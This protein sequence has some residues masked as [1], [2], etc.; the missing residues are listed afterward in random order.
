MLPWHQQQLLAMACY[1]S[2]CRWSGHRLLVFLK[3]AGKKLI[4]GDNGAFV[5]SDLFCGH[6]FGISAFFLLRPDTRV[7]K[8]I[9]I[10]VCHSVELLISCKGNGL[11]DTVE[12]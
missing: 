8:F 11:E 2:H 3:C 10:R 7:K 1:P 5:S 6:L 4:I 12:Q 9:I